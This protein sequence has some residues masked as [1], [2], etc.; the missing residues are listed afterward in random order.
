MEGGAGGGEEGRGGGGKEGRGD[1]S[2]ANAVPKFRVDAACLL[3]ARMQFSLHFFPY[4]CANT[5]TRTHARTRTDANTRRRCTHTHTHMQAVKSVMQ[6]RFPFLSR[7]LPPHRTHA[8][9]VQLL[10]LVPLLL[11]C[12]RLA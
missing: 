5:P 10:V 3:C 8:H 11:L 6:Q 1:T 9:T 7:P 4:L 12:H 2:K